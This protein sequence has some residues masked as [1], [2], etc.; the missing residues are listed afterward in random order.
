MQTDGKSNPEA[1]DSTIPTIPAPTDPDFDAIDSLLFVGGGAQRP[2][3]ETL[4]WV[5]PDE[6]TRRW[7]GDVLEGID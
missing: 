4:Q 3:E 6:E 7:A 2:D 5:E 1:A